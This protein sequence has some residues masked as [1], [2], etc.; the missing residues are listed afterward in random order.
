MAGETSI[1]DAQQI[2]I[3]RRKLFILL[4]RLLA[5]RKRLLL[6][7]SGLHC[8]DGGAAACLDSQQGT[9]QLAASYLYSLGA[10]SL[11]LASQPD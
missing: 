8:H 1:R 10:T 2:H 7:V 6:S 4:Q 11:T 5:A 9:T 3:N